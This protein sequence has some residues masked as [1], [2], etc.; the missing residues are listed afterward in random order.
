[1]KHPS[2]TASHRVEADGNPM[3]PPNAGTPVQAKMPRHKSDVPILEDEYDD[4][5][6]DTQGP[7]YVY[8][9]FP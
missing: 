6:P 8:Q 4:F 7:D 5:L 9:D 3:P 2:D 1:M